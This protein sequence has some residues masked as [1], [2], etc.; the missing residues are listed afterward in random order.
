[1]NI[2]ILIAD[3]DEAFRE[4]LRS[5]LDKDP[6]LEVVA[7]VADRIE[8][9]AR[10][11]QTLPDIICMD[12]DMPGLDSIEATRNLLASRAEVKI[13]GLSADTGV[14]AIM[15]LLNAGAAGYA[16]KKGGLKGLLRAIHG[17]VRYDR[18]YLCPDSAAEVL[19][20]LRVSNARF[21]A[22]HLPEASPATAVASG[23][24]PLPKEYACLRQ[25]VNESPVATF[26]IN[27]D[28]VV[29]HWNKACEVLTGIPAPEVIGTRDQWRAFSHEAR[30]MM[31]DLILDGMMANDPGRFS[32]GG[33]RKLALGDGCY[34]SE[35][36]VP[37]L[38]E[39]GCWIYA[40]S[41]PWHDSSGN[42]IG[43]IGTLQDFTQMRQ[44]QIAF[45]AS[46]AR[47]LRLSITDQLTGLFN[48]R[49]FYDQARAEAGRAMRYGHAL[50]LI[51]ME[52]ENFTWFDSTYG[53]LEGDRMLEKL[54]TVIRSCL[55]LGDSAYRKGVKE[56]ALLLPDT[57]QGSAQMVAERL[58]SSF[59]ALRLAPSL[60]PPAHVSVN[61]GVTR[62]ER[63]EEVSCFIR[64]ADAGLELARQQG[65][66]RIV[67]VAAP[68]TRPDPA[69]PDDEKVQT[70]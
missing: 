7:M 60:N 49:H 10:A 33:F 22:L 1:M 54:A 70:D 38:S 51:S 26:V 47:F 4:A 6:A 13:I 30:P 57:E 21:K 28:H 8:L 17:V 15:A 66:D 67:L 11:A 55:R 19:A 24:A 18:T 58:R 45:E 31:V 14:D 35:E 63:F 37:G 68:A 69:R 50:S 41:G 3:Q 39:T 59:A 42:L 53:H 5:M 62:Y 9:L 29:V 34:E 40:T 12:I 23:V 20:V 65:R 56:F 25:I 46:E 43:M 27:Q 64:R 44:A 48:A 61:I 32:Q 52:A 16:S 2:R 36:F